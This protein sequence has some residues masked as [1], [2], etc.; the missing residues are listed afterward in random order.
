[1][2]TRTALFLALA[3]AAHAGPRTS[4]NYSAAAD[5]TDAGGRRTASTSYTSDGSLG[6]VTGLSTVAAPAETAKAGFIGQLYEVTGLVV[7]G[8]AATV[9]ET[10]TLQLGAWQ[11]LDDA[12][13][14]AVSATSVTWGVVSGP[15]T[16]ISGAGLAT[17]GTVPQNTAATVQGAFDGFTGS[18]NL[19]VLDTIP[20]NFGLYAGDGVDDAWQAQWFGLGTGG[21]GNPLGVASADAD[22]TG[23]TNLFKYIAGLNPLDGS[24]FMLSIAPVPGQPGQQNI[25]F[26]P[27]FTDRTYTVKYR[28]DLAGGT[29]TTLTGTTQADNGTTRTV[30]DPA[31]TG[32]MKFYHIE[33]TKP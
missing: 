30:T 18:L 2:N 10:G 33:I 13:Y 21:Q 9:N 5:T 1:M 6:G 31:A 25:V 12:S 7:N 32:A 14:L 15:I 28:P 4:A 24:R 29:W 3:T 26:S 22:G 16:G 19:T 17:A 27:R 8:A 11:L 20:D 23:Q